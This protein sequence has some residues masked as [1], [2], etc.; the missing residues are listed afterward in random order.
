M[1]KIEEVSF[2]YGNSGERIK[3][4]D[5]LSLEIEEGQ[6]VAIIGPNGSGKST[7]AKLL[8]ALLL[9]DAGRVLVDGID[10]RESGRLWDVRQRVGMV[11]QNPDNQIVATSVEEDVAFGPENLGL[12]PKE[13]LERVNEALALVGMERFRDRAP[14]NLSGGQ[15]QRVAIAGVIAMRPKYL[16]LDEPTAMLDPRGRA[17]IQSTI[18]YLKSEGMG[19]IYIT[20]FMEEAV[21]G[22]RLVVMDAGKI[23]MDGTP[24]QV[25]KEIDLLRRLKLD[26]PPIT[27]LAH[28]LRQEG[29]PV[30]GD[31]LHVE[32][33]VR[34]LWPLLN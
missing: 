15:K 18:E 31:L 3:A 34:E 6:H 8:N 21:F 30:S 5:N 12:P 16:V 20:H 33:M 25:F 17:E 2:S 26:V 32:E 19:V 10:T 14:H 27:A 1:I 29:V 7:L 22:D 4:V 24:K 13:I 9:P 28:A 23:V 11:F